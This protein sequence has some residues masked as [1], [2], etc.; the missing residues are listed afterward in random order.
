[1]Q[2][3][4]A[5]TASSFDFRS[6]GTELGLCQRYF[7]NTGGDNAY[8]QFATGQAYSTNQV[9]GLIVP[10]PA[11][12]RAVPTFSIS[13]LSHFVL[14]NSGGSGGVVS[15]LSQDATEASSKCGAIRATRSAAGLTG[16]HAALLGANNTTSARLNWS[17]EL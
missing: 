6:Y 15:A 13:D 4:K 16:G 2:L 5:T 11:V 8:Q 12:M 17:S 3:E 7:F 14:Q 1:V 10:F 9:N